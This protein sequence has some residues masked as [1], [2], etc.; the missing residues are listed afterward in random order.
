MTQIY[1][2]DGFAW[3]G[4]AAQVNA[5]AELVVGTGVTAVA[6][7]S[8]P[9]DAGGRVITIPAGNNY[10]RN[11]LDADP[12]TSYSV[13]FFNKLS[14]TSGPSTGIVFQ[15]TDNSGER[16]IN[17]IRA[18]TIFELN[19]FAVRNG[20][21]ILFRFPYVGTNWAHIVLEIEE[22][23]TTGSVRGYLDGELIGQVGNINNSRAWTAT[24]VQLGANG[25][26]GNCLFSHV[27]IASQ[28]LGK[29]ARVRYFPV[30]SD[31]GPNDMTRNTG[32]TDYEAL[33]DAPTDGDTTYL[34]SANA[35]E[36]TTHKATV[37][38]LTG[39]NILGARTTSVSRLEIASADRLALRLDGDEMIQGNI[40]ETQYTRRSGNW[41][42]EDSDYDPWEPASL[43]DAVIQ[44]EHLDPA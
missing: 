15:I 3:A 24:R 17:I 28:N 37:S 8:D 16:T 21:T 23:A 27:I 5:S 35:G 43:S 1:Y 33:D 18:G 39:L 22:S 7:E 20:T 30:T 26:S 41:I 38:G 29:R 40:S 31:T 42:S 44:I 10:I 9:G 36:N 13:H 19:N 32:S 12:G 14:S 2:A 6:S 25:N 11:S 34:L 4:T